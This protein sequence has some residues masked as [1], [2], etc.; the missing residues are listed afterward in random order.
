[1]RWIRQWPRGGI[2]GQILP[3]TAVGLTLG[4]FT[5]HLWGLSP[6]GVLVFTIA[7]LGMAYAL[8]AM[9][10]VANGDRGQQRRR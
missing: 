5:R 4:F 9:I 10:H 8:V 3:C 2:V 7:L 6:V 1:M